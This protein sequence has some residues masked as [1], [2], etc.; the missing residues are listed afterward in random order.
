M[1]LIGSQVPVPKVLGMKRVM[2]VEDTS[3]VTSGKSGKNTPENSTH[4]SNQAY[5]LLQRTPSWPE[6]PPHARTAVRRR[7]SARAARRIAARIDAG[8]PDVARRAKRAAHDAERRGREPTQRGMLMVAIESVDGTYRARRGS[9]VVQVCTFFF[10]IIKLFTF[11]FKYVFFF[12]TPR[13]SRARETS[14]IDSVRPVR[15]LHLERLLWVR[16]RTSRARRSRRT[17]SQ[18]N[19]SLRFPSKLSVI[20]FTVNR[21]GQ[22]FR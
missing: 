11:L 6:T 7:V 4:G 20:Y 9:R 21:V 17:R 10:F 2:S 12:V 13:K 19:A 18:K 8:V 22:R 16:S 1:S 14:H 3:R 5:H 15:S